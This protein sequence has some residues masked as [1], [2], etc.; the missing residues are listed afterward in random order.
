[1]AK[2]AITTFLF[3][4]ALVAV[5]VWD[6][7]LPNFAEEAHADVTPPVE[8][9]LVVVAEA[10]FVNHISQ[11]REFTGTLKASRESNLSFERAGRLIDVSVNEGDAV[12]QGQA[13]AV[14]DVELVVADREVARAQLDQAQAVLAE[15]ASGPR[16]EQIAAARARLVSQ[17]SVAQQLENDYRRSQRLIAMQ[18]ISQ[19]V[20]DAAK[21]KFAA[22]L[23]DRDSAREQLDELTAGT[24]RERL[25][26]QEAVVRQL[27]AQI[28]KLDLQI[29]DGQLR[30]P[31]AG[32]ISE[33]FVDEG[34]VVSAGTAVLSIV[35]DVTLEAWI[36]I[37]ASTGDQLK[38]G[39][40]YTLAVAGRPVQATLTS[41]RPKL[42]PTTRTQNAIFQVRV[43]D[44]ST[45]KRS[46]V[47][48]QL[49]RLQ[50]EERIPCRGIQIPT[51]A[52]V[53]GSRGLWS[54][55]VAATEGQT[56]VVRQRDVELLYSLG[57]TSLVT[58][59]LEGGESIIVDGVHRVVAGQ[60]IRVR[61][62]S[63]G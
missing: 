33:R 2:F 1:M 3:A 14:L 22:S 35:D 25:E 11:W 49:V 29:A 31:F 10:E 34:T 46:L 57:E 41:L 62:S 27:Q 43:N 32:H 45:G 48:E 36:G 12:D 9:Q 5:G 13:L 37:P 30:A 38:S 7:R 20:H 8:P 47:P 16:K 52:M 40:E 15:L 6:T 17:A 50:I 19:E 56:K 58:G 63:E 60:Q 53:P 39:A 28:H 54:V 23:S 59:T 61:K 26:A 18:G 21:F 44:N 51:T 4:A 24:R 42:D 55:L